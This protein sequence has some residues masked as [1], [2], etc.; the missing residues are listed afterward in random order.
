MLHGPAYRPVRS[1]TATT[2]QAKGVHVILN[3]CQVED[4][5]LVECNRRYRLLY[6]FYNLI[7]TN[8]NKTRGDSKEGTTSSI[9]FSLSYMDQPVDL[10]EDFYQ[11]AA[12]RWLK[13][14]P[15]PPDKSRWTAFDELYDRNLILL[16]TILEEAAADT[17]AAI[18]STNLDFRA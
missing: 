11:Y 14:N 17:S 9:G 16:K 6:R 4:M 3:A 5:R 7:R 10:H 18:G 1:L 2:C 12:G 13:S 15:V 8:M